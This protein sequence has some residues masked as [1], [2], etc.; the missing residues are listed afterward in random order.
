VRDAAGPAALAGGP[1]ARVAALN[2]T[3]LNAPMWS[4]R[5][6]DDARA[7]AGRGL[8]TLALI[9]WRCA[10]WEGQPG[11]VYASERYSAGRLPIA[12]YLRHVRRAF[13][14]GWTVAQWLGWFHHSYL[15]LQHRRVTLEKLATRRQETAK[16]ELTDDGESATGNAARGPR[17]RGLGTDSP[18][19][20]APRFPS[21]LSIMADLGLI[22]PLPDAAYRLLPDG[23]AL[24]ERFRHYTVPEWIDPADETADEP[25]TL[26]G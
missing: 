3:A 14:E 16:F 9:Y 25:E 13:E 17:Y 4:R 24:L 26:P 7:R 6:A 10:A 2:E 8:L 18:K 21:A 15:W 11:W 1:A 19:M 12:G 23:A 5:T 22:E 20:N